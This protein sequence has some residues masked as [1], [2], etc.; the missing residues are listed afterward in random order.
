M[1]SDATISWFGPENGSSTETDPFGD[2]EVGG[3]LAGTYTFT[4]TYAGVRAQFGERDRD[5]ATDPAEGLPHRLR[6]DPGRA[7]A[8]SLI[9]SLTRGCWAKTEVRGRWK[10][11]SP[12]RLR[13][14]E[15]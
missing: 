11:S 13:P 9:A 8:D 3:L 12:P 6:A 2:Y 5:R 4:A 14:G 1:F 7:D 10:P 15:S